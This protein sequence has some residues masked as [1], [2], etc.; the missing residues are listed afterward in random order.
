MSYVRKKMHLQQFFD[1]VPYT[2][3]RLMVAKIR[4]FINKL[5]VFLSVVTGKIHQKTINVTNATYNLL[6][7]NY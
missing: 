7:H 5:E 4:Y 6:E 3:V 2:P 1:T